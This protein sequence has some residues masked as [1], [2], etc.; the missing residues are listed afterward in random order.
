MNSKRIFITGATGCVGHYLLDLLLS[1]STDR[2]HL[3]VRNVKRL[4]VEYQH[5]P[6][7]TVH[8]GSLD[9]IDHHKD[10]LQQCDTL[11]HIATAWHDDDYA[12]LINVD[13]TLAMFK[14]AQQGQ[15]Q[16]IIYFSTASILS[17]DNTPNPDALALGPMYV[18]SKYRA[19]Q[20][21]QSLTHYPPIYT[22]FPTLVMGGNERI[23]YS[24]ISGG[25]K[26]HHRFISLIRFLSLNGRFHFIHCQ[27]IAE[28]VLH[29]I[30]ND[31]E[32]REFV[33]GQT[34]LTAK[35]AIRDITS[36][37]GK[38]AV[39]QLPLNSKALLKIAQ[40]LRIKI[41]PWGKYCAEKAD[42]THTTTTPRDF[43]RTNHFPTLRSAII[44]IPIIAS[45]HQPNT[46]TA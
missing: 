46:I 5:H 13:R 32:Q 44:D 21:L 43:N 19:H 10:I 3:L 41:D 15:C 31:E 9:E 18:K 37:C 6:Q 27:D 29:L 4:P 28:I 25:I 38:R 42:L 11:I 36:A 20:A 45:L 17:Q 14:M 12:T 8:L 35:Q 24:H 34:A 39:P 1:S 23:P 26:D 16:K 7:V 2:L 40:A 22:V 30:Y 33:L